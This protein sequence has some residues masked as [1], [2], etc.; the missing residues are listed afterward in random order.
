MIN[1]KEFTAEMVMRGILA[2]RFMVEQIKLIASQPLPNFKKGG[3]EVKPF[4]KE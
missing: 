3:I 1:G 2:A 4:F